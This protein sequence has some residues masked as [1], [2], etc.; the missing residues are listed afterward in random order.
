MEKNISLMFALVI[1]SCSYLLAQ[2]NEI[3]ETKL[4]GDLTYDTKLVFN[5]CDYTEP[6]FQLV[7]ESDKKS[8]VLAGVMSALVPGSGEF[9]LGNYLKAGIFFALDVALIATAISYNNKG[10]DREA[11]FE[12]FADE[13]W[14]VVKYA[15][16]LNSKGADISI[17]PD[18]S[19]PPWERVN[20]T[21]LNDA[22]FSN[23]P[24][25]ISSHHLVSHGEQQ[26]YEV[27]GKYNQYIPGWPGG[28][29][30]YNPPQIML[31][32]ARMRGDANS[33]YN[34]ASKIVIGVYVNHLLSAIDAVWS[35]HRYN[36]NLAVNLRMKNIQLA[37]RLELVPT[38]NFK[39]NF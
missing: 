28:V 25:V 12:A 2:K 36:D 11:A 26:Y 8:P 32:Y 13:H 14:S 22:E 17:N 38:V 1:F 6:A 34:T 9:Y 7:D 4:T 18:E 30:Q 10:N 15:E 23:L 37:D 5:N 3:Q 39:Y 33:A 29:D 24:G 19:L 16:F 20:W 31:N 35:A 21:E 27:I